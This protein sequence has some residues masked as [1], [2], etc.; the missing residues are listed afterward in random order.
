MLTIKNK[1]SA[2][3]VFY[4]MDGRKSR[5]I[6]E[7]LEWFREEDARDLRRSD[8][9]KTVEGMSCLNALEGKIW[10]NNPKILMDEES[11]KHGKVTRT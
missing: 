6:K 10:K 9:N 1:I 8:L 5:N 7:V 2:S 4:E 11:W 3:D